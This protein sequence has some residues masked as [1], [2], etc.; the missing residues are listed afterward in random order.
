MRIGKKLDDAL[1]NARRMKVDKNTKI[2]MFSDTHR[3]D[4][5]LSDEFAHNQTLYKYALEHYY[6]EGYTYIELGD[7]DEMWEHKHFRH[8]R[9][10]HSDIFMVLR[11]FFRADRYEMIY[12]NHNMEL[13]K[14]SNVKKLL[15]SYK[16]EF[17]G[18][19]EEL[20]PGIEVHESILL[21]HEGCRNM[22][23]LH[24]HQGDFT[25]DQ[26]WMM[27]RFFLRYFWRFMHIIGFRNPASPAK[28]VHHRHVLEKKYSKWIEEKDQLIIMGHTHRP[29]F[30]NKGELPYFNTGTC[31]HPRN[32]TGIEIVDDK[33]QLVVWK[34]GICDDGVL[35]VQRRV[36]R[37]P[38]KLSD[39]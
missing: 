5:S 7:G 21:E 6:K 37:G 36:A 39:L 25:N 1:R 30:S 33:I 13:K 10:A 31:V 28:S 29:K 16:D 24:G 14:K 8:I 32:I 38:R 2:I 12:G 15:Y 27:N 19:E 11:K 4:N 3:G 35:Q 18:K 22:L 23:L 20:F 9:Y 34:I 17:T 26:L